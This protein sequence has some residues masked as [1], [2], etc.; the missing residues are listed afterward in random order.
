MDAFK[1]M[2]KVKKLEEEKKED[3]ELKNKIF[4]FIDGSYYCFYRYHSLLN[5]WKNAYPL[6]EIPDP[7]LNEKFVEKFRKTFVENIENIPKKLGLLK[8]GKGKMKE[9]SMIVGKDCKRSDIWRN[10]LYDKYK[11]TRNNVGFMGGPLFKLA[12]DEDLFKTAGVSRTL[13]HPQLEADDCIALSVRHLLATYTDCKI[14]I[15]TSDKDYLQLLEPR[16]QIFNLAFKNLA[17]QKSYPGDPKL[18]LFCKIV[19]GDPSDNISQVLRKCGEKTAIKYYNDP[20]AFKERLIAENA[21]EKFEKNQRLIDFDFIP[22]NLK[23]E[24]MTTYY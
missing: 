12:Y 23:E 5:W 7:I 17:E 11:G 20:I 16:V 1:I 2:T 18:Q 9:Y 14:Y 3:N 4:I 24:F 6:E 10:A 8:G 13:Y 19:T 21:Q 15:I 22:A